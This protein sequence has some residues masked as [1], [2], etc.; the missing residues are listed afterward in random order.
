MSMDIER[1]NKIYNALS[2]NIS[3]EIFFNRIIWSISK[4]ENFSCIRNIASLNT[5]IKDFMTEINEK[6]KTNEVVIFGAGENGKRLYRLLGEDFSCKYFVD[7]NAKDNTNSIEGIP[8]IS[9]ES[10]MKHYRGE[11]IVISSRIYRREIEEQLRR[12]GI[13]KNVFNFGEIC[14]SLRQDQY[15]DLEYMQPAEREIFIDAGCY[16]ASS[17]INFKAWCKG[18]CFVY[19]FEPDL[20]RIEECRYN[21][22]N[23]KIGYK[24]INK[25]LWREETNLHFSLHDKMSSR[26]SD[27]GVNIEVTSIDKVLLNKKVTF[28][29]MD[30]EGSE[31]QALIGA[32]N[33]IKRNK[34]KLAISV[35]HKLEDIY[36]V[37]EIILKYCPDYKLYLRHY[38]MVDSETVLYA[39]LE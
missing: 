18:D 25:G 15:F 2:D 7:S 36:E 19:A 10:F 28:I 14:E 26:I 16:D 21:L 4:G 1:L 32:E 24:L 8:V 9:Y 12:D 11:C 34:P 3:K 5:R 31:L 38:S 27:S 23:N 33:V 30:I 22:E 20:R 37:P 35:Y 6:S 29:K 13:T 17:S 39:I